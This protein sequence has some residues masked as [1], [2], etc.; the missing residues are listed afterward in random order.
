MVIIIFAVAVALTAA[1]LFELNDALGFM[2]RGCR[3]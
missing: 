1:A 3:A 2:S